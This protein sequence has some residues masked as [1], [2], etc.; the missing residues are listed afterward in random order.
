MLRL[1]SCFL[2]HSWH[3]SIFL[4]KHMRLQSG[5]MYHVVA[6]NEMVPTP[7]M[8]LPSP[9]ADPLSS[10][11][12]S[13]DSSTTRQEAANA[14]PALHISMKGPPADTTSDRPSRAPLLKVFVQPLQLSHQPA[15]FARLAQVLASS[16]GRSHAQ[17]LLDVI[18]SLE[19][20][21]I[22]ALS[23]AELAL[24]SPSLPVISFEV[25]SPV[26]ASLKS[27]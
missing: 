8:D 9:F 21:Q 23:V 24:D 27:G 17:E 3:R 22:R 12:L 19:S 5:L 13:H 15:C 25:S 11:L 7:S 6:G 2:H 26:S 14:E 4:L 16:A 1:L 10:F 18:S 20:P